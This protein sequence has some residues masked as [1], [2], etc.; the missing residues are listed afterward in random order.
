MEAS[1]TV[2]ISKGKFAY[3]TIFMNLSHKGSVFTKKVY[4]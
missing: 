4:L 3:V 1:L 2:K